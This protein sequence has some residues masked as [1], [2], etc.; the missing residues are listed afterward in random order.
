MRKNKAALTALILAAGMISASPASVF[1]ATSA[2]VSAPAADKS[3]S[4]SAKEDAD[5][6]K[7]LTLAKSRISIPAEYSDFT[8]SASEKYAMKS[9][10]FTWK[11]PD[12][13][14]REKGE[15]TVV[16]KGGII[17][18]YYAPRKYRYSS[19]YRFSE[20]SAEQLENM[21]LNW[22][23][24]VNPEMKGCLEIN[25]TP[26][27]TLGSNN[28]S[29]RFRRTNGGV[30]VLNNNIAVTIDKITGEITSYQCDWWQNA[31]FADASKAV[32]QETI[33][34]IYRGEVKLK[35]WYRI[36]YDYDTKKSTAAIVYQPQNSFVYNALTGKHST[37]DEDYEKLLDTDKYFYE[38]MVVCEEDE[39][40]AGEALD[41]AGASLT[42]AEQAAL[43]E[44]SG[45]LTADKFKALM[46]KD[47]YIKVTE[48][49]IVESYDIYP[50]ENAECGYSV[51]CS[52]L[53]NNKDEYC[54]Y[55]I[56]ADAK[57]GKV[58][59]FNRSGGNPKAAL[60]VS[61][62]NK[63][64]EA[65]AEYY[66]SDI[67][68]GYKADT[69]NTAP[70]V[71]TENYTET[72]RTMCYYRYENNIQVDGN[73]INVTVNSDGIVTSISCHHTKDVDFGDGRIISADTALDKLFE[74]KS[75]ELKYD[76]FTDLKSKPN[77]YLH[78]TMPSWYIN[79]KTGKLCDYRGNPVEEKKQTAEECPYKD[80]GK[81]PYKD[82]IIRLYD[83]GVSISSDSSLKP[84]AK[85][86]KGEFEKLLS[87]VGG[88][89]YPEPYMAVDYDD[90]SDDNGKN[91]S[92]NR[93]ITRR[94]LAKDFTALTGADKFAEFS[95]IYRSP[96][97]DVKDTD[98]SIGYIAL[99]YGMGAIDADKNG[100]FGPDEYV[101]REYALHCIYNYIEN[102]SDSSK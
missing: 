60:D 29:I 23:Y 57:S 32:S 55:Y 61:K 73:R 77:T 89:G 45:L 70:S 30:L 42:A 38:D 22:I 62:A 5:M 1:A 43:E 58:C 2:S 27:I 102:G 46:I 16:V 51:S 10:T 50:D 34:E 78:Y 54:R 88:H 37:M 47:P 85:I 19:G 18:E 68:G 3:G 7:A 13:T 97:K 98:K 49:Y 67:F 9:Y 81:S 59:S 6:K 63:L 4:T 15:Y 26:W 82:E 79:A 83:H 20:Y 92:S 39:V 74:Q 53:I 36:S 52:M 14:K 76:G 69:A 95:G 100:N 66:Y 91:S 96:F 64:A 41:G 56:N 28:V 99:A 8:Y 33:Q 71:K 44:M 72:S 31:S 17:R 75:M 86:T 84:E 35:P 101:T 87:A 93:S 24:K 40:E 90:D 48:K 65:A 12:D 94:E 25:G 11:V 80:I 21:A